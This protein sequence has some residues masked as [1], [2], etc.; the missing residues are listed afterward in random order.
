MNDGSVTSFDD[1]Y[2]GALRQ[3]RRNTMNKRLN[4]DVSNLK[5][6]WTMSLRYRIDDTQTMYLR[7]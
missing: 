7:Q 6:R 5:H 4:N 3:Q 1:P 2:T